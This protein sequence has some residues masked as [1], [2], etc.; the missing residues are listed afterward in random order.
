M[1]SESFA[2]A[3]TSFFYSIAYTERNFKFQFVEQFKSAQPGKNYHVIAR[4]E[5][6]WQSPGRMFVTQKVQKWHNLVLFPNISAN[7]IERLYREIAT[8]GTAALAMTR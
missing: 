8:G 3:L 2:T 6:T 1:G 7:I 5:A 4:S